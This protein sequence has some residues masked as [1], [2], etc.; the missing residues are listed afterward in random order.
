MG[1][2]EGVDPILR[3]KAVPGSIT[4]ALIPEKGVS[5]DRADIQF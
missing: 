1:T 3:C 5:I 4:P 2:I